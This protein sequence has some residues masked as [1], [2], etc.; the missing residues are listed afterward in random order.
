MSQPAFPPKQ[1]AGR[2]NNSPRI[3]V[4]KLLWFVGILESPSLQNYN[5]TPTPFSRM[6]GRL[7]WRKPKCHPTMNGSALS[8]GNIIETLIQILWSDEWKVELLSHNHQ[9]WYEKRDAEKNFIP[10]VVWWWINLWPPADPWSSSSTWWRTGVSEMS[11]LII[12]FCILACT[13]T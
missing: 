5:Q 3:T 11:S 7:A 8:L 4:E 10:S 12:I 1:R 9:V 13:M 6:T 2:P